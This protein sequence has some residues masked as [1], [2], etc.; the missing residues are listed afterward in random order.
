MASKEGE[1]LEGEATGGDELTHVAR[2]P[3]VGYPVGAGEGVKVPAVVSTLEDAEFWVTRALAEYVAHSVGQPMPDQAKLRDFMARRNK[4]AGRRLYPIIEP[5][6]LIGRV[7]AK[8]AELGTLKVYADK[9]RAGGK[10]YLG[11]AIYDDPHTHPRYVLVRK[12][13]LLPPPFTRLSLGSLSELEASIAKRGLLQEIVVRPVKGRP[14]FFQ[15]VAGWRRYNAMLRTNNPHI[16]VRV[17]WDLEDD[18]LGAM[19]ATF[20]ENEDRVNWS[21]IDEARFVDELMRRMGGD[22]NKVAEALH[23]SKEWVTDRL[24]VAQLPPN[25]MKRM[26]ADSCSTD[27]IH[28]IAYLYL[29]YKSRGLSDPEVERAVNAEN[30]NIPGLRVLLESKTAGVL[31]GAL[32]SGAA[33]KP[34]ATA[35]AVKPEQGAENTRLGGESNGSSESATAS[36]NRAAVQQTL[37]KWVTWARSPE[38]A[39]SC[40]A[41]Y[42]VDYN[43]A[44][45]LRLR[46]D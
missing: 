12:D 3:R 41:K 31:G 8:K 25:V 9:E 19:V 33:V 18:D 23:K 5:T 10:L 46:Y 35:E 38:F 37:D 30:P 21:L 15:V 20:A 34:T 24:I 39:C 13:R 42:R 44:V 27:T 40:G 1:G 22:E 4:E 28:R 7:L 29:E 32:P 43:K 16:P 45:I 6:E 26:V 36:G 2:S 11:G 14:G 17:R